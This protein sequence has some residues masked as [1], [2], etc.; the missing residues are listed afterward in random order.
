MDPN[1]Y[2]VQGSGWTCLQGSA[3]DGGDKEGRR[4]D[5]TKALEGQ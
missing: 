2:A 5:K 1:P 3:L 4:G